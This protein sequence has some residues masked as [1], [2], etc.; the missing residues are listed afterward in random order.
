MRKRKKRGPYGR[1]RERRWWIREAKTVDPILT[2]REALRRRGMTQRML[3]EATKISLNSIE[4]YVAREMIP[5][6][7]FAV[8][9]ARQ[10]A[11][12]VDEIDWSKKEKQ[13]D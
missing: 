7:I 8:R 2:L 4:K 6:V 13:D 5:N 11:Y 9:I 1:R 12:F 10:L 3:S